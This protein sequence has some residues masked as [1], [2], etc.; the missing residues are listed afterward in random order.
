MCIICVEFEL[1]NLTPTE[2]ARNLGEAWSGSQ[3][4]I[5]LAKLI[6]DVAEVE[7]FDI[8]DAVERKLLQDLDGDA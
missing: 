1:G 8:D 7:D 2:A 6:L 4:D 3:H 5:E